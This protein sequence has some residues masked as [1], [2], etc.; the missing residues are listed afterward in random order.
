[1]VA[2]VFRNNYWERLITS[3]GVVSR[4]SIVGLGKSFITKV[5]IIATTRIN[6]G[7][8]LMLSTVMGLVSFV[9]RRRD[10]IEV[11]STKLG[12]KT[13]ISSSWF[14]LKRFKSLKFLDSKTKDNKKLRIQK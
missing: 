7:R 13:S 14:G 4:L 5:G 2:E 11:F 9:H 6:I 12:I 3:I 10:D 1:L 8:A